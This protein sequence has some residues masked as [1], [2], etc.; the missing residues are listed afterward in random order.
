M[1]GLISQIW[2]NKW[3][4]QEKVAHI[5]LWDLLAVHMAKTTCRESKKR[6]MMRSDIDAPIGINNACPTSIVCI[7][8]Q[9]NEICPITAPLPTKSVCKEAETN[10]CDVNKR[11][12]YRYIQDTSWPSLW[13]VLRW[14]VLRMNRTLVEDGYGLWELFCIKHTSIWFRSIFFI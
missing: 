3:L 14:L 9:T 2:F 5:W 8:E 13:I 12:D 10:M 7:P 4:L 6:N 11:T 1:L